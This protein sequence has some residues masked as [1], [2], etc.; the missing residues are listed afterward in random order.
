M[1]SFRG[2]RYYSNY[3][4]VGGIKVP[5]II[6]QESELYSST[7]ILREVKIN[8]PVENARFEEP[9]VSKDPKNRQV[10]HKNT[11][12][13]VEDPIASVLST[14]TNLREVFS[15][16]TFSVSARR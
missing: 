8:A 1:S 13:Q 7:L 9:Q 2:D 4:D 11:S 15:S 14:R 5:F 10:F 12:R 16:L 3:R 6:V